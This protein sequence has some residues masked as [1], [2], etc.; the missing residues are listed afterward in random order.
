VRTNRKVVVFPSWNLNPYLNIMSL[1]PRSAGW[2]HVDC[3]T[4]R[5]GMEQVIRGLSAG[6]ILHVHW[7]SPLLQRELS[8]DAARDALESLRRSLAGLRRRG[9][10]LVWTIHNRLPHELA[11][12]DEE[13]GLY[14]LLAR[15]ADAIHVMSPYTAESLRDICDLPADRLHTIHHPSFVGVYGAPVERGEA[16]RRLGIDPDRPAVL[17][18][19]QM[20]AYKGMEV[21]FDALSR[22]ADLGRAPT[23]LLAGGADA[24]TERQVRSSLPP[25]VELRTHFDFV[26]DSEVATW[27]GAADL[28]VFPYRAILNSGS[29][30]LA[31]SYE[32]PVILPDEPQLRSQFASESWV[33]YFSTKDP[34]TSLAA[35]IDAE[36]GRDHTSHDFESFNRDRSPWKISSEYRDLL[37]RI[38]SSSGSR[39]FA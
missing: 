13:I 26:L 3:P 37:G 39:T 11:Y 27:F 25:G 6:D 12:R 21:L 5:V 28:A 34:V 31:A 19:G 30:H 22:L 18:F 16:R 10:R 9:G 15:E 8:A 14:R 38:S 7:T 20:R 36:V 32:T 1:A 24:E 35:V 17:F 4:T 33:A 2:E 29:V 23:L